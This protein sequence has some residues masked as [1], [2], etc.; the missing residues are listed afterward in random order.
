MRPLTDAFVIS[1]WCKL[2]PYIWADC[3]GDAFVYCG[4]K[5][6]LSWGYAEGGNLPS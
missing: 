6:P 3:I 5:R 2:S 4:R 1:R